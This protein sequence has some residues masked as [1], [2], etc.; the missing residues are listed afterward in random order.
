MSARSN[1]VAPD[2]DRVARLESELAEAIEQQTATSQV[3]EVIGRSDFRLERVLETVVRD[4]VRLCRADCGYVYQLDG[5]VYRIAFIVG[6]SQQYREYMRRH[7]VK[8]GP[9]TLV[10]RVALERRIVQIPDVL[11]DPIYRWP[12]GR[13]LGGYRTM[14]GAP[15]LVGDRVVGVLILWR[16]EVDPFGDRT[17]DLLTTFAAQAAIAIRNVSLFQDLTR[18][19]D[20][21]RALGEISQAVSSSL[22]LDEVLTTIVTRAVQLSGTE[23]GSIFEFDQA[24]RL[25]HLRTCFGTERELVT[26]LR[27]TRIHIDETFLGR[28]VA[29]G[30]PQGAS[31]LSLDAS[32]PHIERLASAGWRSMLVVPLRWEQEII[33]AL[34]VRRR[35][36]G[37]FSAGTAELLETLAS[38][39]AVAIHNARV[40]RQLEEKSHQLEVAGRHKSEFLASMSHELRTPLNAVIGFSDVLLERMFGDLNERQDEYLRD[41]R[42]SGRH[43][44]EL[45]NEILDLSKV[46]AGKMELDPSQLKLVPILEHGLAM[47]RERAERTG[48]SLE[49]RTEPD[50]DT[51]WADELKLKQLVLN[52][53][54]NA[55]KFTEAGGSVTVTARENGD[56]AEVTVRDTGI[57]IAD[58]ERERIFEAFERGGRG[59]RT[60]TEG[61]GLGLTLSKRIV[62]LHGGRLWMESVLGEGS[63]FGFSLPLAP[64]PAPAPV[65]QA[66]TAAATGDGRR[67]VVVIDDDPL[68]LDL[69]EALLAPEGYTVARAASGEEGVR[70]V[71]HEHPLVV[72]LDLRMPD[73]DGF[74]VAERL[75]ADPATAGVPIIVLTHVEMTRAER[76]RLAGRVSH[77]AQKGHL[78]RAE[79]VDL[80]ARLGAAHAGEQENFDDS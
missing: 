40:F 79:L 3:L 39:S 16:L 43:L 55:V 34:V 57:G 9:E 2:A 12:T 20:E 54:T 36:P 50:V 65:P 53:L 51:V 59:V 6:G 78:D 18:S 63:R 13:E 69:V 49:L 24:T 68:D 11:A 77:L 28:A 42:D 46:E 1:P 73:M 33:G 29:S 5:D 70:L 8:Q 37:A 67:T 56:V 30:E 21:L 48:I 23:G 15:M 44:L 10:G 17:I 4:A 32:D 72:L 38:Q 58:D 19:V 80:V 31:D 60:T 64:A 7:P 41:I 52:L 71:R 62:E 27:A 75:R 26:A 76:D 61:T 25:F 74:E 14:L 47:V 45:I 66:T 35:L 22:D